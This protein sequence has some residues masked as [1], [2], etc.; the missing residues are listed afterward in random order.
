[1]R[2]D[3]PSNFACLGSVCIRQT[4]KVDADCDDFCVDG[5]C[6]PALGACTP[7]AA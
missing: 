1:V 4:C 6:Y 7:P 2:A 5:A 3:C